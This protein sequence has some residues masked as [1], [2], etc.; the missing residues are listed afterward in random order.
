MTSRIQ[1]LALNANVQTQ[2]ETAKF[3]QKYTIEMKLETH[4]RKKKEV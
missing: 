2:E 3:R 1:D 4:Q